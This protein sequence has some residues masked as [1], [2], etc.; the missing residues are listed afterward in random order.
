MIGIGAGIASNSR[1][2]LVAGGRRA[3]RLRAGGDPA[4]AVERLGVAAGRRGLLPG[5]RLH[6]GAAVPGHDRDRGLAAAAGAAH[7]DRAAARLRPGRLDRARARSRCCP[8]WPGGAAGGRAVR[9]RSGKKV[10]KAVTDYQAA[11]TDLAFLRSRM[12]RGSVGETGRFWH[13]EA[14]AE[15]LKARD[16]AIGHPEAL[17]MA[18][19]HHGPSDWAP[20]PP[21]PPPA[22][23]PGQP[24]YPT[25]GPRFAGRPDQSWSP[26]PPPSG[27]G[28]SRARTYAPPARRCPPGRAPRRTRRSRPGGWSGRPSPNP[29][30]TPTSDPAGTPA[31]TTP[32]PTASDAGPR[33][34]AAR[35][36]AGSRS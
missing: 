6:H 35:S 36:G 22:V 10:A 27:G 5:V 33:D 14:L 12:A 26:G 9:R 16:R 28:R 24:H 13:G 30:P 8:A 15:L 7:R 20:P 2:P 18:L 19:R 32:R 3:D 23:A 11:V 34:P 4:R 25:P 29:R 1:N 31:V 17:T 21:G